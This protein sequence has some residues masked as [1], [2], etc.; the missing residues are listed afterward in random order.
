MHGVHNP[1]NNKGFLIPKDGSYVDSSNWVSHA[2]LRTTINKIPCKRI[3]VSLDACYSGIFGFSKTKPSAAA[4]ELDND[5]QVRLKNAFSN[6]AFTRKYI[7]AGGDVRVPAKSAFAAQWHKA[8]QNG[9]GED[10]D[11]P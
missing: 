7:A 6:N 2:Q 9:S 8:L 4:W 10:G 3:L 1:N 11:R 5:C